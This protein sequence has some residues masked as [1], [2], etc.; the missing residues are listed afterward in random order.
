MSFKIA[1]NAGHIFN[2]PGKRIPKE[3]DAAET[4]EWVLNDRVARH[5]ADEMGRYRGV[6]LRRLDDPESVK[7]I[8]IDARVAQ[9][10][11]W[12]ADFYLSI[13]HNAAGRIFDGGGVEVYIDAEGGKSEEYAR[14]IYDAVVHATRLKGNRADPIR[15][16]YDGVKLYET[17]ATTMPAVLVE[18]GYMDSTVDAPIILTEDYARAAGIATAKAIAK[19]AGLEK[20]EENEMRYNTLAEV[21]SYARE[22]I[23][24]LMKSGALKG[25]TEGNLNLSE[26]MIRIIVILTRY[27]ESQK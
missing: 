13:H 6:E 17:R 9:A 23:G 22:I 26:D 12:P 25:D 3:L 21:P 16:T 4:R 20:K 2:T 5:F 10:N 24:N 11:L 18:Y 15:S 27:S 1:Y 14:A 19:I 8:D 7:P